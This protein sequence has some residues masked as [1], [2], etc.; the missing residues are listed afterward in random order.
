MLRLQI[1][2]PETTV[3]EGD[4]ESVTL[5]TGDGE[6]TVL[7]KHIPLI[8]TAVPGSLIARTKDGEQLFAISRGTIEVDGS[9]VSVLVRTADSA[10]M[11]EDETAILRAKE[12]AEKL[13]VE[14]RTDA[15]AFADATAVLDRELARLKSVRRRT[16]LRR[17]PTPT[18]TQQ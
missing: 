6:I 2:T 13:M 1:I 18:P 5:P 10:D 16:T 17:S 7:P 9:S 4:V 14:K 12:A 3:F 15:E 8:T 11:L